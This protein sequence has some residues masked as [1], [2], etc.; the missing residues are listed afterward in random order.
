MLERGE[1]D[2]A[3]NLQVE[4]E[5]LSEMEGE[6]HGRIV[7]AFSSLV[8]RIV[9]NQTN[10]DAGLGDDRSEY[11]DG[12]NPH[13][14]LT[15][16]PIARAL[17]MAIDRRL[18]AERLYG[19]A[20]K[21]TCNLITGPPSYVSTADEDCLSQDIEGA[22]RLLDEAGVV[23]G[24]GDGVREYEE[25][26]LRIVYQTSANSIRRETQELVRDWWRQIGVETELVQHDAA[27]FFGGDPVTDRE[28]SYRRFFADV[29]MFANGPGIDPQHYLAEQLCAEIPE[30]DNGWA[31]GNIPR[32]CNP[33]YDVLYAELAQTAD[34]GGAG[35]LGQ[36][37]ERRPGAELLRDPHR[38]TRFRLRPP[39][40][41]PGRADQR[42]GQRDVEHRGVAPVAVEVSSF[43]SPGSAGE[44]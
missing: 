42:V 10:P 12:R 13:P 26:P 31:G 35:G 21:P 34:R 22:K 1:A 25:T 40:Y 32:G 29:Q 17:S 8:E 3:W 19:F 16:R 4:P 9:L 27:L 18:I 5:T 36:A 44:G 24:D 11:L 20:G 28:A 41:A 15:H 33:E 38:G 2:Y 6:G 39:E 7:S 43:P 37:A 23:D 30:R 14:F